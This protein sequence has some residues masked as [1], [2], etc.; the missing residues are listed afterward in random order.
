[1]IRTVLLIFSLL[2]VNVALSQCDQI[3]LSGKVVDTLRPRNFYNLMIINQS[4]GRG[5]FGLANGSFNVYANQGDSIV[6]SVE[7]YKRIGTTVRA[8]SNCQFK[9]TWYVEAAPQEIQEVVVKPLK[10]L[11]QI[12]EERSAL[13]MR[14]TRTVTGLEMIQ[15]PITALYETFSKKARNK[16]MV[17]EWKYADRQKAIVKELLQ[18]YVVYDIVELDDEQFDAFIEFLNLDDYFLKTASEME[19]ITFIQDKF[20]HFQ[21]LIKG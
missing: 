3:L 11:S 4:S 17:E 2:I 15:S 9:N 12:Q 10:T 14:E 16:R 7:G 1:M 18:L 8:D 19:L 20:E 13:A 21:L 6:F 5:V